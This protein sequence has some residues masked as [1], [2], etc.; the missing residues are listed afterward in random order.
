MQMNHRLRWY[1]RFQNALYV[2]LVLALLGTVAWLGEQYNVEIDWTANQRN[3]LTSD[4]VALLHALDGPV[5][6]TVYV[7]EDERMRDVLDNLLR[8][9]QRVKPDIEVEYVNPDLAPERARAAGVRFDGTVVVKYRDRSEQLSNVGEAGISQALARLARTRDSW[10][11]VMAGHGERAIDGRANFDLGMLGGQLQ[12][13]GFRLQPLNLA[14]NL[15]PDN[16]EILVVAGPRTEWLPTE[17]KAVRDYIESGGNLLWLTDPEGTAPTPVLTELLGVKPKPGTIVDATT[18]LMG[19]AD[20]TVAVVPEYPQQEPVADF[21]VVTLYPRAA[22]LDIDSG[23]G[24]D[25]TPI[26]RT[27]QNSWRETGA[28]AGNVQPDANDEKGPLVLGVALE[29]EHAGKTQRAV[30]VGDGD[31]VSN[32]VVANQGNMDLASNLFQWL[33]RQ[34][35]LLNIRIKP[36]PDVTLN[37][38]RGMQ[39]TIALVFLLILPVAFLGMGVLVYMRRRRR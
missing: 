11:V 20:P 27:T 33:G 3:S 31:F 16:T 26:L 2:L 36:A 15:L 13:Q 19:V 37:L 18:Q 12:Q 4:S 17:V 34:D 39:I 7:S 23:K 22:A 30:V 1:L 10:V 24:W 9:F 29:R 8:R 5:N 35:A 38:E 6:I 28:L 25:I 21:R 14:T 32:S